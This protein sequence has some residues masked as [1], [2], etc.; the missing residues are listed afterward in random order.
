VLRLLTPT[1]D[2]LVVAAYVPIE[3]ASLLRKLVVR[4][5]HTEQE[6]F[7]GLHAFER[8]AIIVED[9]GPH[10]RE[11]LRLAALFNHS[12]TFDAT[13]YALAQSL[14]AEFWVCD[15]RFANSAT[16]AGL[17]GFRFFE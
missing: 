11:G 8:L 15:K 5:R 4:G 6:A 1:G 13:G 16:A 7:D 3:F 10:L 17:T 2:E 14:G 9:S 12:D